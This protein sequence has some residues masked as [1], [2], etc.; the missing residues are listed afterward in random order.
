MIKPNFTVAQL[1]AF[2]PVI[3]A[4][5]AAILAEAAAGKSYAEIGIALNIPTIGTIKSRLNRARASMNRAIE[6]AADGRPS[7]TVD[8]TTHGGHRPGAGRKPQDSTPPTTTETTD[9]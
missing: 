6:N 1:L 9:A 5:H 2:G 4:H 8:S 3:P 7:P